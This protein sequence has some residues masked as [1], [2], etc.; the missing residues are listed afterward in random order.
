MSAAQAE[1]AADRHATDPHDAFLDMLAQEGFE[2]V[3]TR[4]R[5]GRMVRPETGHVMFFPIVPPTD[6]NPTRPLLPPGVLEGVVLDAQ[7][8][9]TL[10]SLSSML[11][12][13]LVEALFDVPSVSVSEWNAIRS[14][15][16]PAPAR[17]A[18]RARDGGFQRGAQL[19]GYGRSSGGRS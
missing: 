4:M 11:P 8:R 7:T 1:P 15:R 14:R 6:L 3:V 10:E 16:T 18:R 19:L 2:P 17:H 12:P 5:G 13:G 9:L